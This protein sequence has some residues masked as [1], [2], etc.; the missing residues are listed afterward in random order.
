MQGMI[1][2]RQSLDSMHRVSIV[3]SLPL[4]Y[5][6]ITTCMLW[7][8]THLQYVVRTGLVNDT[9]QSHVKILGNDVKIINGYYY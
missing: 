4:R 6:Y 8:I 3:L 1:D 7:V 5:Y 2:L 9:K